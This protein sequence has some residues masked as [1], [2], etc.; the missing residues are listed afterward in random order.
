MAMTMSALQTLAGSGLPGGAAAAPGAKPLQLART[1]S[2][3]Y[4]AGGGT[5]PLD[6]TGKASFQD[7]ML[8]AMEGVAA[9]QAKSTDL[10]QQMSVDP[11][12]VDVQ[13]VT[14]SMAEANLSLN[15]AKTILSRVVSAWR[16]VI[17]IR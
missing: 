11:E 10:I 1:D 15:L 12:S 14:I 9:S 2:L 4:T 13:D 6:D 5:G 17:N 16:D 7:A 3:H 8:R